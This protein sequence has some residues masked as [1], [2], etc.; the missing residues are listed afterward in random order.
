MPE[1]ESPNPLHEGGQLAEI[2]YP[3]PIDQIEE[4]RKK[5][6]LARGW[7]YQDEA[8]AGMDPQIRG[9]WKIPGVA[10]GWTQALPPWTYDFSEAWSLFIEMAGM[11]SVD[12]YILDDEIFCVARERMDTLSPVCFGQYGREWPVMAICLCYVQWM[13]HKAAKELAAE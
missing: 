3:W 5:I 11:A 1:K 10:R 13:D 4:V 12:M 2:K 8:P 7:V 9:W 6:A